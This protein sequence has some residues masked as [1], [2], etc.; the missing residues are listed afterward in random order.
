MEDSQMSMSSFKESD[1]EEIPLQKKET[2]KFKSKRGLGV[3][4]SCGTLNDFFIQNLERKPSVKVPNNMVTL[5]A[6]IK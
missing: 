1:S 4:I 6:Q 3:S 5:Q 2:R